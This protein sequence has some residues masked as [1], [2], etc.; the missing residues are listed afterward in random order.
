MINPI[1]FG[2]NNSNPYG[3]NQQ[4]R[5]TAEIDNAR[6][7]I[8]KAHDTLQEYRGKVFQ[9][10]NPSHYTPIAAGLAAIAK[11]EGEFIRQFE[12]SA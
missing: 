7:N 12:F 6:Q 8:R 9:A 4:E 3:Q 1:R 2:L 5:L 11:T 10:Y